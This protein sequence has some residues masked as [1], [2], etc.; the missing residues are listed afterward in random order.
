M[1]KRPIQASQTSNSWKERRHK[2]KRVEEDGE[3][4]SE[5]SWIDLQIRPNAKD[6]TD[7]V[8]KK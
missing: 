2:D 1:I 5:R 3:N 4:Y 8:W 7:I 6:D